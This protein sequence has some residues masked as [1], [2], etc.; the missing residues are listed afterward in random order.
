M[1]ILPKIMADYGTVKPGF[2][3]YS[4]EILERLTLFGA[5][6]MNQLKDLDVFFLFEFKRFFPTLFIETYYLT[7][8]INEKNQYSVIPIDDNLK[9][10]LVQFR[11]GLRFPVRGSHNL[12]LYSIWEDIRFSIEYNSKKAKIGW[13]Y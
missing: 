6:S 11:G 8:N 2:Y 3:F 7:R 12:E 9:F 4:S 10:R 13:N 5:A 1:F